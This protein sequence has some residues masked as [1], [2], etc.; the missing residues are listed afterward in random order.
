MQTNRLIILGSG[1][2]PGVP[3]LC[4]GYGVCNP[5]N[6]K[7]QRLRTSIYLEYRGIKLLIDTSPDLRTQLINQNI[8]DI[9]GVLYTHCHADHLHGI[10]ELREINRIS[11]QSIN[12][13]AGRITN[14]MIKKHFDYLIATAKK[15][16]LV[17]RRPSL[18]PNII[19]ANHPFYIKDVKITP[20]KMKNH[21]EECL[22]YVFD[23]GVYVHIADFKSLASSAYKMI[24]QTPQL[25]TI[26]L[27]TIKGEVQHAGLDEVLEVITRINP[28]KTIVNHLTNECDYDQVMELTPPSVSPAYDNLIIEFEKERKE[29]I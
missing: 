1:A 16:N 21:C 4:S 3:S 9:D 23:D 12:F 13:Y 8:R 29:E 28:Y 22:G 15:P 11:G 20:I 5:E 27:T 2:A 19:K 6:L 7:N 26:P 24:T 18:I 17:I 25:L 14:K 10:D